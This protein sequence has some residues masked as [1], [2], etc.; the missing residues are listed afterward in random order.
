MSVLQIETIR[1][2]IRSLCAGAPFDFL[3]ART[4][5]DFDQ[6]PTGEIDATF[7]VTSDGIGVI[8]GFNF[9]EERTDLVHIWVA[10][11]LAG[12]PDAAYRAL[13][14][15]ISSLRA[16]V[17]RDGVSTSG[18]YHVPDEGAGFQIDHSPGREFAVL[19]LDLPV[20]Y[21]ALN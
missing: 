14:V 17:I 16:A 5:F 3:P 7:R 2:R 18:D 12:D 9:T 6:Q 15:D 19:R 10:R 21:E 1:D 13:Q 8:G 11:K 20:N 4:P